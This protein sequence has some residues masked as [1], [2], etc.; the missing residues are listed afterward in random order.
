MPQRRGTMSNQIQYAHVP[1]SPRRAVPPVGDAERDR[2][3]AEICVA[4]FADG[5]DGSNFVSLYDS[6][7]GGIN[8]DNWLLADM[9]RDVVWRNGVPVVHMRAE[10]PTPTVQQKPVVALL[11]TSIITTDGA[12]V[13]RT[14]SHEEVIALVGDGSRCK[15]H[16][17]HDSTALVMSDLLGFHVAMSR[18]PFEH[19]P[20]QVALVFKLN[21][22]P[23]EGRILSREEIEAIG[24]TWKPLVRTA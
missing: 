21:G 11:N 7:E 3:I 22:R 16:I 17:E 8:V 14:I 2:V 18:V 15:S 13:C 1:N 9:C 19:A 24:Y 6:T 10:R 5:H 20:L 23:P 4:H 12:Y